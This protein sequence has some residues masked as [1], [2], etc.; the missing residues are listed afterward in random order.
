MVRIRDKH[1]GSATRGPTQPDLS[2][3]HSTYAVSFSSVYHNIDGVESI[4]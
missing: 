1:S 4:G 2:S 3:R